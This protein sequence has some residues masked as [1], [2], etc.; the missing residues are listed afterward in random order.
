MKV[1]QKAMQRLEERTFQADGTS[2]IRALGRSIPTEPR[3]GKK[4]NNS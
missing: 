1:K 3:K 2:R 4:P